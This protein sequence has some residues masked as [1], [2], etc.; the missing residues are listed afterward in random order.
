MKR[1]R[2]LLARKEK[3]FKCREQLDEVKP[4]EKKKGVRKERAIGKR[5]VAGRRRK[6]QPTGQEEWKRGQVCRNE[7]S[8]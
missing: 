8:F 6:T 3:A 2:K 1:K 7:G 5:W 4:R